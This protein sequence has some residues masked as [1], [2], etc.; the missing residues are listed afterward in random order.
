[1]S[2]FID[3]DR[4]RVCGTT[5]FD[6]RAAL[7]ASRDQA[8]ENRAMAAEKLGARFADVMEFDLVLHQLRVP[9]LV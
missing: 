6:S 5:T 3:R 8:A 9:E 4:G 7:E 2:M 1:M